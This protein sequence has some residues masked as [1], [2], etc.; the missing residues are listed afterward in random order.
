MITIDGQTFDVGII[1]IE[2]KATIEK[3]LIGTTIDGAN[4]YNTTGTRYD[5]DVTFA[6][7]KMNIEEYNRLYE[8]L[9]APVDT[10]SVTMPYGQTTIT[11]NASIVGASDNIIANYN[12]FR[13]WSE[14]KISFDSAEL[15]RMVD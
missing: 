13:R 9:T 12:N 7:K 15:Q 8:V 5:Y 3:E 4:H 10:H 1:N 2:R 11:F 14:L 6:T